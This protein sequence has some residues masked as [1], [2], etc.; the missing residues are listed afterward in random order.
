MGEVTLGFNN[1]RAKVSRQALG[2]RSSV[3][4]DHT[5]GDEYTVVSALRVAVSSELFYGAHLS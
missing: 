3:L 2:D 1:L 4:T 5:V